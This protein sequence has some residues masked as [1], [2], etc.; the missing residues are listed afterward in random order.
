MARDGWV[1]GEL[2]APA[3]ELTPV[4]V[5]A[6]AADHFGIVGR[7]TPLVS[8]RD[9][10]FRIVTADHRAFVLKVSNPKDGDDALQLQA[11]AMFH[12]ARVDPGLPLMRPLPGGP[13]QVEVPDEVGGRLL[14][15]MFT[16]MPGR[17]LEIQELTP[18]ALWGLG[19]CSARMARSLRGFFHPGA[20]R[21]SVWNLRHLLELKP[22]LEAVQDPRHR[23]LVGM[24]LDDFGNHA[25]A[26]FPALRAQVIHNDLSLSNLVFDQEQVVSGILDFGD[27]AHSALVAELAIC[28]ESALARPDGL[29][30]LG[31][32]VGGFSSV[33]P[34]EDQEVELLPDLLLGR[35]AALAIIS[36]WRLARYPASA[37]YVSGWQRGLWG[38]LEAAAA[39]GLPKWRPLIQSVARGERVR[40]I[41]VT[42]PTESLG[43]RRRRLLGAAL[44]PLFYDPPL[45]LVRGEGVWLYDADGRRYLDAYNNVPIVGHSHPRVA[46]AVAR[47]FATLASNTRYLHEAPLE[48]AERL[49]ATMPPGLDTVLFVNSGSEANDLAW[50]LALSFT[51]GTGGVATR[52][53]YHGISAATAD[54]SPEEWRARARPDWVE[55]LPAPDGYRGRHRREEPEWVSR[56]VD[57]VDQAIAALASRGHRP[58]AL[59]IDS[60]LSSEGILIPPPEY[61]VEVARRWRAAGGL[62]VGDEVQLGFGRSGAQMW[63]FQRHQVVPDIVTVGKPM[64]NGYPIAAVVTRAEIVERFSRDTGWFST[65]GGNQVACAAGLA[66]LDVLDDQGL[67]PHARAMGDALLAQ[68]RQLQQRHPVIGEVRSLGLLVGVE[69]VRER[70]TREP[71]PVAGIANSMRD[72]GVLVGATGPAGNV[73]KIRPPLVVTAAQVGM[74]TEALDRALLGDARP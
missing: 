69:L 56:Y 40:P 18:E 45:H 3:P 73:I 12:S 64:G 27:V 70:S 30:A 36:S 21:P 24:A 72:L 60:G 49:V 1:L 14:V 17:H 52:S 67:L 63:G 28:A 38:M 50:R 74:V 31:R 55:T 6:I 44:S 39:A 20:A 13:G 51:G 37:A 54:L 22:L 25:Q 53:A 35:W 34:L 29:A 7:A 61:L 48:L 26:A 62:L 8:E 5:E 66:V 15:R 23:A 43:Q 59:F 57:H 4:A 65:F 2:E 16:F 68:L 58:A 19:V 33:T 47:Q 42:G 46:A 11:G 9:Q 71:L 10:N 32:L 41:G